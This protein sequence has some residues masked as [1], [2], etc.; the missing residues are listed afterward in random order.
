[1]LRARSAAPEVMTVALALL[2]LA[3]SHPM[4]AAIAMAAVP[5]LVLA[6][7]PA[8]V[9]NSA[10]N[11]VIA[12]VFPTLFC[13]GAFAYVSWVFPGSGWSFLTTPLASLSAW[14]AATSQHLNLTGVLALDAA[15]AVGLALAIAAP[16]ALWAIVQVY[17]RRP[18]LLPAM[19][20]FA[21]AI[22]A[23]AL[24]VAT[25]QFGEP[26]PVMAAAPILC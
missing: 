26:V 12:L 25:G 21:A 1:D 18:L 23:A 19:V 8:L 11:V 22:G 6:V 10:L 9:A 7:R 24:T 5:F 13:L 16:A 20:L 17:R 14:A 2:G 3:F 4:G 15:I